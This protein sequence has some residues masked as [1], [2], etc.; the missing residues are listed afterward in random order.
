MT[1]SLCLS[2]DP[3]RANIVSSNRLISRGANLRGVVVT[4]RA[5]VAAD[6][7]PVAYERCLEQV[8][9]SVLPGPALAGSLS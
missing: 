8:A 5:I 3:T 9:R 2:N 1:V 7:R 4:Y 6:R